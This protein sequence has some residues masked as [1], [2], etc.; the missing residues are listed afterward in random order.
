MSTPSSQTPAACKLCGGLPESYLAQTGYGDS[1]PPAAN[2]LVAMG[3]DHRRDVWRCPQCDA[4]F[5][6]EDLPQFFGSGNLDEARLD[7]LNAG[8]ATQIR[9]LLAMDFAATPPAE[10]LSR[11]IAALPEGLLDAI[12]GHLKYRAEE[13]EPLVPALVERLVT[14]D[15]QS[16]VGLLLDWA[17]QTRTRVERIVSRLRRYPKLSRFG[18][19]LLG[20]AEERLAKLPAGRGA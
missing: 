11:A 13:F 14:A 17:S 3:F 5:D 18:E 8:Q 19:I 20:L 15:D 16:M 1:L 12:L 2:E 10:L 4:F 7:R 6:F 9:A